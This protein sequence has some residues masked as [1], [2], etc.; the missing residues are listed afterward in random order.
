MT[1]L[2]AVGISAHFAHG[3]DV[4]S[5]QIEVFEEDSAVSLPLSVRRFYSEIGDGLEFRWAINPANPSL[6]LCWLKV[7][8]L[9]E[10]KQAVDYLHL[11]NTCFADRDLH[12]AQNP[13]R[14]RTQYA[15]QLS[16]FPILQDNTD[17]LCIESN[18]TNEAVVFHDHE[19]SFSDRG[20]S[21][22]VLADSLPEFWRGWSDV[23]YVAPK[24]NW[25]PDTIRGQGTE[26]TLERFGF[27][28]AKDEQSHALDPAAGA[29][30]N[31]TPSPPAQ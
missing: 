21:G 27:C 22:L 18:Q 7:P 3:A 2:A 31:G 15:R 29:D 20:V 12:E 23:G 9:A 8:Q 28:L 6:P 5:A 13:V 11:L 25:W 16:F 24:N 14:A 4:T 30:S 17:L 19:W 10:L 26:W 1:R